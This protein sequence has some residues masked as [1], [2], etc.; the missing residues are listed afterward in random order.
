MKKFSVLIVTFILL[1]FLVAGCGSSE[2]KT[3]TSE[4]DS[5]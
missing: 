5:K 1:C 3:D 2:T 4:L